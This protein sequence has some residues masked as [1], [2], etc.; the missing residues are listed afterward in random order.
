MKRSPLPLYRF[1]QLRLT[2]SLFKA[3]CINKSRWAS[4]QNLV[5][6]V[7]D[8]LPKCSC[9]GECKSGLRTL[10]VAL[11]SSAGGSPRGSDSRPAQG[12]SSVLRRS[13][14][15]ANIPNLCD[16]YKTWSR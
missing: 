7:T 16:T 6:G 15:S 5:P 11:G 3:L 2:G 10:R 12:D 4:E 13:S 14:W 8:P 1:A 9:G